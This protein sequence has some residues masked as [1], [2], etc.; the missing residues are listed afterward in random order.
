MSTGQEEKIINILLV[1]DNP[2]DVEILKRALKISNCKH[3]LKVINDGDDALKFI[4]ELESDNSQKDIFQPQFIILDLNLPKV[5]G[6]G[7]LKAI[8]INSK[9]YSVPVMMLTSSDADADIEKSYRLG[10][11]RFIT[12]PVN[13]QEFTSLVS[14]IGKYCY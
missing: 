8:K 12:K 9:I 11:S 7:I 5:S 13:P 6:F 3:L 14:E 1:E 4:A 10:A 2:A